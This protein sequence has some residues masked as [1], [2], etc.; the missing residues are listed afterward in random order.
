MSGFNKNQIFNEPVTNQY[1]SHMVMTNVHK[2]AKKK[3]IS[4]D[5]K[6]S[7]EY[8]SLSTAN[9]NITLPER[10]NE[11]KELKL[12]SI[13]IPKTYYNI[14]ANLGNNYFTV[15]IGG[16]TSL[17]TIADGNY[18]SS[19]LKTTIDTALTGKNL[20]CALSNN[21]KSSFT[22]SSGTTTVS[23]DVDKYGNKD[24]YNFKYKLGWILGFRQTSYEVSAT[25]T[26]EGF[27]NLFGSNYLYL[28][29][30]EYSKSG[31]QNSFSSPLF[32]SMVNKNILARISI[33]HKSY[34]FGE[35]IIASEVIGTLLTDTRKYTGKIDLQ[36]INV[37]LL[38]DHGNSVD[39]NGLDFSFCLEVCHE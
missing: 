29:L 37:Q 9:F 11:I 25:T 12:T 27:L 2:D 1:G 7:E 30:D 34:S 24:K 32:S 28:A 3:Y 17:I 39:L 16:T 31:S 10:V 13:E 4:I 38:N 20:T 33:D 6:N 15:T 5:T 22:S 19:T 21:S 36:K 8:N 14:S 18:T 26:S 35:V 23:F